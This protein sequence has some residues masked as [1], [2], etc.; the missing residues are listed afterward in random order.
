MTPKRRDTLMDGVVHV[1]HVDIEKLEHEIRRRKTE[2]NNANLGKS[3]SKGRLGQQ[4]ENKEGD[5][6]RIVIDVDTP[7]EEQVVTDPQKECR[8]DR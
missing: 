6:R 5:E 2:Q 8:K 1:S 7:I 4:S 3:G